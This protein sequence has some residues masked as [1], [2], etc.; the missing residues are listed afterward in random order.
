MVRASIT[1]SLALLR[2]SSLL[3]SSLLLAS[4]GCQ[5]ILPLADPDGDGDGGV[6]DAATDGGINP[7]LRAPIPPP[8]PGCASD[9][10]VVSAQ[11]ADPKS[12]AYTRRDSIPI[13]FEAIGAAR[14][15]FR[16]DLG[17]R[18]FSETPTGITFSFA[19]AVDPIRTG[20][21]AFTVLAFDANG[22]AG[23]ARVDMDVDGDLLV[24]TRRGAVWFVGS[25]GRVLAPLEHGIEDPSSISALAIRHDPL[26]VVMGFDHDDTR[27]DPTKVPLIEFNTVTG[28][29]LEFS[30]ED[31]QGDPL[32]PSG[33]SPNV[34]AWSPDGTRLWA[35]GMR[36]KLLRVFRTSGL[37]D[38]SV[39][40]P[41]NGGLTRSV[42]GVFLGDRLYAA[43]H[44]SPTLFSIEADGQIQARAGIDGFSPEIRHI[45]RGWPKDGED[46][47]LVLYWTGRIEQVTR[48]TAA[49]QMLETWF[50]D[51]LSTQLTRSGAD[52][53][54][55]STTGG[56][57]LHRTD[58]TSESLLTTREFTAAIGEDFIN[59]GA[60]IPFE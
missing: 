52:F 42:L 24:G 8:K 49:G 6:Q 48:Y 41:G 34:L 56:I 17:G 47:V 38:D 44:A 43:S 7:S 55:R 57:W 5:E 10:V 15:E 36:D 21:Y 54:V 59:L 30:L 35:D 27:T 39:E 50:V 51:G 9:A 13:A 26:R 2:A 22:C 53:L 4:L 16:A 23:S 37:H 20:R 12:F 46:T 11:L 32:Y 29:R 31:I 58:D 45:A 28:E 18:V 3:A 33:T 19:N 1:G 60:M 40:M 14:I 25:D